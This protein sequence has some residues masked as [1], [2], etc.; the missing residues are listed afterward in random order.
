MS[1]A[2]EANP[3]NQQLARRQL[4][5]FQEL[6]VQA[7]DQADL[8]QDAHLRL[9]LLDCSGWL[10]TRANRLS[11]WPAGSA[12]KITLNRTRLLLLRFERSLS[13]LAGRRAP[14]AIHEQAIRLAELL[15]TQRER[16]VYEDLV[17]V[18][19]ELASRAREAG[20]QQ[21]APHYTEMA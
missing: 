9:L 15:S 7:L 8:E 17:M 21:E 14:K 1:W 20:H 18:L 11:Q 16:E 6:A 3:H 13:D 2:Y 4:E 19:R 12:A 10:R 5:Q